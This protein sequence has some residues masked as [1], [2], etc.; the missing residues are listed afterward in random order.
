MSMHPH[1]RSGIG[2]D[3]HNKIHEPYNNPGEPTS[4]LKP[5]TNFNG[6]HF[7]L[8]HKTDSPGYSKQHLTGTKFSN[9]MTIL[10]T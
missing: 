6:P 10:E 5:F 2:K 1:R 9:S 4:N 7:N 8:A 3:S